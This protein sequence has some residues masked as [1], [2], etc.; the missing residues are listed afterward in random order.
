MSGSNFHFPRK[1]DKYV[2][3]SVGATTFVVP[4]NITKIDVVL[5][6]GGGGGAGGAGSGDG[7]GAGGGGGQISTICL[8]VT[9][10]ET[11]SISIGSGGGG[12]GV[13]NDGVNGVASILSG[14]FGT[15][16]AR[17]G[18]KG[19]GGG[20]GAGYIKDTSYMHGGG[21]GGYGR[22]PGGPIVSEN[23]E[24]SMYTTG[25][26]HAGYGGGGGGG[27]GVGGNGGGGTA[28]SPG[29]AGILGAGGGG[30][31]PAGVGGPGGNGGIIIYW[32]SNY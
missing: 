13:N 1:S 15:V 12:G 19:G 32:G 14:S 6:A 8:P 18:F 21:R 28:G 31:G 5:F 29:T 4:N 11:L 25:G 3:T 2:N 7:S 30:G 16:F 26:T 9:P 23:G 20:L 17:G 22:Q 10:G 27:Y 24:P